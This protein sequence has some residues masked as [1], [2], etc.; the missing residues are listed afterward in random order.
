MSRARAFAAAAS[1]ACAAC[2]AREVRERAGLREGTLVA[3]LGMPMAEVRRQ[4]T[5]ELHKLPGHAYADGAYF[6]LELPGTP[7]RFTRCSGYLLGHDE[8]PAETVRSIQ[9]GLSPA[10]QSWEELTRT[11][12]DAAAQ[13]A[14][15]GWQ[16]WIH[17]D[18][19]TLDAFLA[20]GGPAVAATP[21]SDVEA[22]DFRKGPAL[23]RLTASHDGPRFWSHLEMSTAPAPAADTAQ[24]AGRLEELPPYPG[25]RKLC[26]GNV[27]SA[28]GGPIR[29]I[30]WTLYATSDA[31]PTV[32]AF[33]A[34]RVKGGASGTTFVLEGAEDNRL[35]V[36]AVSDSYP[37]CGTPPS[38]G[39][40]AVIV[41]SH[42]IRGPS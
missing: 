18:F 16:P 29:E 3:A 22:F 26:D 25:A 42:A 12:R 27:L 15:D 6:D 38:A 36:H 13:L 7:L 28:P 30:N 11:L 2:D 1:L 40:K 39:D 14:A 33:Y 4:S 31:P 24:V 9:V 21:S 32:A 23:I 41:V 17:D 5:L 8:G 37:G 20:R 34:S 10:R 19:P 35:S